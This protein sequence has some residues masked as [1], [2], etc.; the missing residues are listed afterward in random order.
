MGFQIFN[1][2]AGDLVIDT[3]SF[4]TDYFL[5]SVSGDSIL[6]TNDT[7]DVMVTFYPALEDT[8][9]DTLHWRRG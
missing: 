6:M 4:G 8:V 2:G 1:S 7:M 5:S 9:Y 3:L